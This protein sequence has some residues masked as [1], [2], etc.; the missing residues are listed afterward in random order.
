[1]RASD[2]GTLSGFLIHTGRTYVKLECGGQE[3]KST[4]AGFACHHFPS[5]IPGTLRALTE[6]Q[7]KGL[8]PTQGAEYMV[9]DGR[10]AMALE[11]A[12]YC[13]SRSLRQLVILQRKLQ[14]EI[15]PS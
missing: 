4:I 9:Y 6:H 1:M 13:G 15:C 11:T 12:H 5:P 8:I 7:T 3:W 2:P 10:E 14:L